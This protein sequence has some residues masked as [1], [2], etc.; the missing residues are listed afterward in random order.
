MDVAA[1][2]IA[3]LA[4]IVSIIVPLI[5]NWRDIKINRINLESEYYRDIY[6][7][8]LIK[9]IPNARKYIGFT[10]NGKLRDTE[11][12][13]EELNCLRQDSLYFLY[14]DKEYYDGLKQI[15]Q[16]LE[17]YLLEC[18]DTIFSKTERRKVLG[19]I[20]RMIRELYS[21]ISDNYLGKN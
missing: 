14:N 1:L 13:R 2:I 15:T 5:E 8:H 6:K 3:I 20:Q 11:E 12:L 9:G 16:D 18:E 10:P 19:N 17:D 4:L 7:E 21:Y